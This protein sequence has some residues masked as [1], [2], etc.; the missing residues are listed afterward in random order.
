MF[1]NLR[2]RAKLNRDKGFSMVELVV[3]IVITLILASAAVVGVSVWVRKM[4]FQQQNNYARTLFVAAQN[5]MIDYE[6]NGLLAE[7]QD[8]FE[9]PALYKEG[10]VQVASKDAFL[11]A[12]NTDR[13]TMELDDIWK[14]A[15]STVKLSTTNDK[16]ENTGSESKA[17]YRGKIVSVLLTADDYQSYVAAKKGS[18][19]IDKYKKAVYDLFERYLYDPGILNAAVCVEFSPE[20]GQIM[21]V[22][23][24]DQQEAF[25]YNAANTATSG[26]VDISN[27]SSAYRLDR[28]VGYYG[29][30]SLAKT[31][32]SQ[33][34]RPVI[35]DLKLYNEDTLYLSFRLKK[36]PAATGELNYDITIYDSASSKPLVML[37]V[38]GGLTNAATKEVKNGEA[39]IFDEKGNTLKDTFPI[40]AWVGEDNYVNVVLDAADVEATSQRFYEDKAFYDDIE[41]S[42]VTRQV[43]DPVTG[44]VSD[45]K[46]TEYKYRNGGITAE[47]WEEF[48]SKIGLSASQ[49][50]KDSMSFHRFGVDSEDIYCTVQ[51]YGDI[52]QNTS[53]KRTNTQNTYFAS[54]NKTAVIDGVELQYGIANPRHLYNIRYYE[55]CEKSELS[56]VCGYYGDVQAIRYKVTENVDWRAA[57]YTDLYRNGVALSG[58]ER[59]FPSIKQLRAEDSLEGRALL[60]SRKVS[61]MGLQI[62]SVGNELIYQGDDR[63]YFKE[64]GT[65]DT[66]RSAG[67]FLIN[68]GTIHGLDFYEHEVWG[69]E[70]VGGI[71]AVNDGGILQDIS[72]GISVIN[73]ASATEQSRGCIAGRKN[74]GAFAGMVYQQNVTRAIEFQDL[75]NYAKVTEV[76]L[77]AIRAEGD[78]A[79]KKVYSN[80]GGIAGYAAYS[81]AGYGN[82]L[83][84]SCKNYGPVQALKHE[85]GLQTE[86]IGGIVGY[87][88]GRNSADA[89]NKE[90]T[91]EIRSCYSTPQYTAVD[92]GN[93]LEKI[94]SLM[95]GWFVGGIVGCNDGGDVAEC[96][97]RKENSRSEGYIFGDRYVGGIIGFNKAKNSHIYGASDGTMAKNEAH[98]LGNSFVGGVVGYNPSGVVSGWENFGYVGATDCY[99]GGITGANGVVETAVDQKGALLAD[100]VSKV[101]SNQSSSD[102]LVMLCSG[103][104]VNGLKE[105][106]LANFRVNGK[107]FFSADNVGGIAGYNDGTLA[108]DAEITSTVGD[109]IQFDYSG[110]STYLVSN[111]TGER[112]VGG[113][114]GYN[115]V[116]SVVSGYAVGGGVVR[117]SRYVGGYVGLNA[118][119]NLLMKWNNAERAYEPRVIVSNPNAV[120]GDYCVGG[121]MGANMIPVPEKDAEGRT[122]TEIQAG[123]TSS[124]F[125]GYVGFQPGSTDCAKAYVGGFIGYNLLYHSGKTK[126][127][128]IK[129]ELYSL[130]TDS[131]KG[132][133]TDS[134]GNLLYPEKVLKNVSAAHASDVTMNIVGMGNDAGDTARFGG[135]KGGMF[136][137]GVLGYNDEDTR[138]IIRNVENMSPVAATTAK[139]FAGTGEEWIAL[140]GKD[141]DVKLSYAGGI[142]GKVTKNTVIVQ[143]RNRDQGMVTSAGTYTG[144]L[145]EVNEGIIR[146]CRVVSIGNVA[147]SHVGGLA[148]IN[149]AAGIIEDSDF[150]D[151]I[152][153]GCNYVGGITSENYGTIRNTSGNNG[154][155]TGHGDYVG[156]ITG[157]NYKNGK[158]LAGTGGEGRAAQNVSSMVVNVTSTGNYVGGI[159]GK[160]MD[161][162]GQAEGFIEVGGFVLGKSYVGG[163]IGFYDSTEMLQGLYNHA[164]V[165]ATMGDVAGIVGW[166]PGADSVIYRCVN[167]GKVTSSQQGN[168]AGILV[169]NR[170]TIRECG[171]SGII[172]AENGIAGGITALNTGLVEKSYLFASKA[173]LPTTSV[174]FDSLKNIADADTAGAVVEGLLA[175]GGIAGENTVSQADVLV[176]GRILDCAVYGTSVRNTLKSAANNSI[177]GITAVNRGL[178]RN[179]IV[180]DGCTVQGR[181]SESY[182]GGIAGRNLNLIQNTEEFIQA[183]GVNVRGTVI[184]LDDALYA[185][186]GGITAYNAAGL[187]LENL[188]V[189][190]D[191]YGK[192]GAEGWAYGGIAGVNA[193]RISDCTY[194]G[195]TDNAEYPSKDNAANRITS[196]QAA[197]ALT[198]DSTNYK[199][200]APANVHGLLVTGTSANLVNAGGITGCNLE[201]GLVERCVIGVSYDTAIYGGTSNANCSILGGVV[202]MNYGRVYNCDNAQGS[203]KEVVLL[204]YAGHIGGIVG[205]NNAGAEVTGLSKEKPM[206]T[207]KNWYI[208]IDYNMNDAGSGG[209]IGYSKS[210]KNII[211]AANYADIAHIYSGSSERNN[212]VA[213]IVGR[214]ENLENETTVYSNCVNYGRLSGHDKNIIGGIVGRSKYMGADFA[215]CTNYGDIE[216]AWNAAGII[217]NYL[218]PNANHSV[219]RC[220]NYGNLYGMDCAGGIVAIAIDDVDG[221]NV[222]RTVVF[223]AADCVNYG[224]IS[225]NN[226]NLGGICGK[227]KNREY[228]YRCRNYGYNGGLGTGTD[229]Y[230]ISGAGSS[231]KAVVDC[232]DFSQSLKLTKDKDK[233]YAG[234]FVLVSDDQILTTTHRDAYYPY[235][236]NGGTI[237]DKE[238]LDGLNS[239]KRFRITRSGTVT[240]ASPL[241]LLL[242]LRAVHQ[243]YQKISSLDIAWSGDNDTN[244]WEYVYTVS[245]EIYPEE[246][247]EPRK[248]VT[249]NLLKK[250]DGTYEWSSSQPGSSFTEKNG[251]RTKKEFIHYDFDAQNIKSISIRISQVTGNDSKQKGNAYWYCVKTNGNEIMYQDINSATDA[252]YSEDTLELLPTRS[253]ALKA[254][255]QQDG[256]VLQMTDGTQVIK[257]LVNNPLNILGAKLD[258]SADYILQGQQDKSEKQLAFE[259]IEKRYVEMYQYLIGAPSALKVQVSGNLLWVDWKCA[260]SCTDQVLVFECA[261][262]EKEEEKVARVELPYGIS[263]YRYR[264]P[265]SWLDKD[266]TVTIINRSASKLDQK[267]DQVSTTVSRTLPTPMV[268]QELVDPYHFISV[269]ENYEDYLV[270]G[271]DEEGN[272]VQKLMDENVVIKGTM[273]I[274]FKDE[275]SKDVTQFFP[276]TIDLKDGNKSDY[277]VEIP[278]V[279]N[280]DCY[281]T[282]YATGSAE[283]AD[284]SL[285][286]KQARMQGAEFLRTT[287]TYAISYATTWNKDGNNGFYGDLPS[288]V[289]YSVQLAAKNTPEDYMY[290]EILV[291]DYLK[292]GSSSFDLAVT[293]GLS[294]VSKNATVTCQLGGIPEDLFEYRDEN[295]S[296]VTRDKVLAQSYMW[297]SQSDQIWFGHEVKGAVEIT[298]EQ[299]CELV[300][301]AQQGQGIQDERRYTA[302]SVFVPD[303]DGVKLNAGYRIRLN[304]GGTYTIYYSTMIHYSSATS[305]DY[306]GSNGYD[307]NVIQMNLLTYAPRISKPQIEKVLNYDVQQD[308]YIFTWRDEKPEEETDSVRDGAKF[309]LILTGKEE[310]GEITKLEDVEL[311]KSSP[312]MKYTSATGTWVYTITDSNMSWNYADMSVQVIRRGTLNSKKTNLYPSSDIWDFRMPERLSQ[313]AV[314]VLDIIDKNELKYEI[315]WVNVPEDERQKISDYQIVIA[316]KDSKGNTVFKTV[317][318]SELDADVVNRLQED[319]LS[320]KPLDLTEYNG[321]EVQI[322]VRVISADPAKYRDGIKGVPVEMKVPARLSV[323]NMKYMTAEPVYNYTA[324]TLP[325]SYTVTAG[326]RNGFVTQESLRTNGI[327]LTYKDGSGLAEED[328]QARYEIAA[329]VY[330]EA[331]T[332]TMKTDMNMLADGTDWYAGAEEVLIYKGDDLVDGQRTD[333]TYMSGSLS[334]AQFVFDEVGQEVQ[335]KYAGRWL[336]IALRAVSDSN[337]SSLWSDQDPIVNKIGTQNYFWYQIPRVQV[338]APP[339]YVKEADLGNR[340]ID[341]E[342]G[343]PAME[344]G[345]RRRYLSVETQEFADGYLLTFIR[346]PVAYKHQIDTKTTAV[347]QYV[348]WMYLHKAENG[349]Q[350]Y[351]AST[352]PEIAKGD[353]SAETVFGMMGVPDL[354]YYGDLAVDNK[355][356]LP[357]ALD[358]VLTSQYYAKTELEV[359]LDETGE[360]FLLV[361]PDVLGEGSGVSTYVEENL[362]VDQLTC[363]AVVSIEKRPYFENSKVMKW[364]DGLNGEAQT[365]EEYIAFTEK[366]FTAGG[367]TVSLRDNVK[368]ESAGTSTAN[369]LIYEV[370][371][372]TKKYYYS[373]ATTGEVGS[374]LKTLLCV[375]D[376]ILEVARGTK[377]SYRVAAI[378]NG[379]GLSRWSTATGTFTVPTAALGIYN[380]ANTGK[381]LEKVVY[382]DTTAA[383]TEKIPLVTVLVDGKVVIDKQQLENRT[384]TLTTVETSDFPWIKSE[385]KVTGYSYSKQVRTYTIQYPQSELTLPMAWG[386]T[387]TIQF[388]KI[389]VVVEAQEDEETLDGQMPT[390]DALDAAAL[391]ADFDEGEPWESESRDRNPMEGKLPVGPANNPVNMEGSGQEKD[392]ESLETDKT[393]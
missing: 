280:V 314:P 113:V 134:N 354:K 72:M 393:K 129:K 39:L 178:I 179:P 81:D 294:H 297:K 316:S 68:Y 241:E 8:K 233:K 112:F 322:S 124:N 342:T 16:K 218:V 343:E 140:A 211:W 361:L 278:G 387:S 275:N 243:D 28:M 157:F 335:A 380:Q 114:V 311:T 5:Q 302:E 325:N 90:D 256:Y 20:A 138:L 247:T 95:N 152:I 386:T 78:P 167:A 304:E 69:G 2:E 111:I 388:P 142:I 198:K 159:V 370:K 100:N 330:M 130:L 266:V 344:I 177:G 3:V 52:Y 96:S 374:S 194:D 176:K 46:I 223:T 281:F 141:S 336:K 293:S 41:L 25:E 274:Q 85:N 132:A 86:N 202:G 185:S 53:I 48:L 26:K 332:S 378:V 390:E 88:R 67:L 346:K 324:S 70:N 162:I 221:T 258:G 193:G 47:S 191:I 156:G 189:Q 106:A 43:T 126:D 190:A 107:L 232:M 349:Y 118:S 350:V 80:F 33:K 125:L 352:Q 36:V 109:K 203:K 315:S 268:H 207:G 238:Y 229:F 263:D 94:P 262:C 192:Y 119:V 225:A 272:Q 183:H 161:A 73:N 319:N 44:A 32:S 255:K 237:S 1:R 283:Y 391:S 357:M 227:G 384:Y 348:D 65:A 329:A 347:I 103:N 131:E 285:V 286:M 144:G 49:K 139:G 210:G 291:G 305:Q 82:I 34:E 214:H 271:Y 55:D 306:A 244:I 265:E 97:T 270:P 64:D 250:D 337:I 74:V 23:Y 379:N 137:G 253:Y 147:I 174:L 240:E 308:Q 115:D 14:Q 122:I 356:V 284:S 373:V 209:V 392:E 99:A 17:L 287:P 204:G 216:K 376:E 338:E 301:A 170:G 30:D 105:A 381:Q 13:G 98:V 196:A 11:I 168:A 239:G 158:I 217:A 307:V 71:C 235:A 166:V 29:V 288:N 93:N 351:Y 222:L 234:N 375:G 205:Y 282:E 22:F 201:K 186:I 79:S 12:I 212:V 372:G 133:L 341:V 91:V 318:A 7:L 4:H 279:F 224:N 27:R 104:V 120:L 383:A 365:L 101:G 117:G 360:Y 135:V 328:I 257:G 260:A 19:S 87:V 182:I 58:E 321:K 252:Y 35:A 296:W 184:T 165:T 208:L 366:S 363:Q 121:T 92:L 116:H 151:A 310:S 340:L 364:Y 371:I 269:L 230:A 83:I 220:V 369:R 76:E 38:P 259:E 18:G 57:S 102:A 367:W 292:V 389:E 110:K 219:I 75:V 15:A 149:Y 290:T 60:G 213:G 187:A 353:V 59:R 40:L 249:M 199:I 188:A 362:M 175:A 56:K 215:D 246:V 169:D 242:E 264:I 261:E 154:S 299:L 150:S 355:V 146:E 317:L 21:S 66:D 136:V 195:R 24:S 153:T 248:T 273:R 148:G 160:S 276:Y 172:V 173:S 323:P 231:P 45:S 181:V 108:F 63:P 385:V 9:E 333:P 300:A 303:Q 89:T 180:G 236:V 295:G 309:E 228:Y 320:V 51:G 245:A 171:N 313:L 123:F 77:S 155:V 345:L 37:Q 206:T 62:S 31:T 42:T 200:F 61:V 267:S 143:C 226:T 377:C 145:C 298:Y 84:Y 10:T 128:D 277:L 254:K 251:T 312:G 50:M 339:M 127:E 197:Y 358:T 163:V 6:N 164:D 326:K 368:L 382:S 359:S 327:T 331:P 289:Y 54:V 334:L